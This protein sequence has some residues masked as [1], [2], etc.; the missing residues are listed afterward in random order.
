MKPMKIVA[1]VL[2]GGLFLAGCGSTIPAGHKGVYWG[3]FSGVRRAK[4]YKDGWKWHWPWNNIVTYDV[5]WNTQNE[6][7]IILSADDLHMQVAREEFIL[8]NVSIVVNHTP[9]A[10]GRLAEFTFTLTEAESGEPVTGGEVFVKFQRVGE[11][12][13]HHGSAPMMAGCAPMMG[14]KAEHSES[15]TD[16]SH[17]EAEVVSDSSKTFATGFRW[18]EPQGDGIFQLSH[19]FESSGVYRLEVLLR[20]IEGATVRGPLLFSFTREVGR[21]QSI[22]G[23]MLGHHGLGFGIVGG[24]VS[25]AAMAL[26]M[27]GGWHH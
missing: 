27:G 5:R 1:L 21:R 7:L 15:R 14:Q 19:R 26:M 8:G 25:L 4:V 24:I 20:H 10:V 22:L 2:L 16:S 11:A 3:K 12:S 18:A 23:K 9:L 6:K 13:S 17:H